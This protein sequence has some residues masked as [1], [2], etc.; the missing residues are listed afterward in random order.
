MRDS[1][2][3][4]GCGV[5]GGDD[6]GKALVA[7]WRAIIVGAGKSWVLFEYGTCVIL[8]EP[9]EDLAEQATALL[10]EWGPV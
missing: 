2:L 6:S 8:M 5:M 7:A 10:R 3:R 1:V 9:A 4:E